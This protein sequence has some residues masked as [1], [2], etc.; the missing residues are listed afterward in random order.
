MAQIPVTFTSDG[1]TDY[2]KTLIRKRITEAGQPQFYSLV[3]VTFDGGKRTIEK[4]VR[5]F[6]LDNG[7]GT[8]L[9]T[10]VTVG[11]V[12]YAVTMDLAKAVV[13]ALHQLALAKVT[14]DDLRNA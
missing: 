10:A 8:G 1:P 4:Q 5:L 9:G 6:E 14:A 12:E 2:V 13:K 3:P 11:G 7:D